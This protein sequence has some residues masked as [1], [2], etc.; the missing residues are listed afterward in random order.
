MKL[1]PAMKTPEVHAA[2]AEYKR[3]GDVRHRNRA[4]AGCMRFAMK[5]ARHYSP[6]R[7]NIDDI[8]QAACEGLLRAA[9]TYDPERAAFLTY[10]VQWIDRY[11]IIFIRAETRMVKP[12]SYERMRIVETAIREGASTI[13]EVVDYARARCANGDAQH[14][15]RHDVAAGVM[16]LLAGKDVGAEF[17]D[18]ASVH[19][20]ADDA[21][22]RVHLTIAVND[23]VEMLPHRDREVIERVFWNDEDR[24]HIGQMQ[25]VSRERIRQIMNRALERLRKQLR[26]VA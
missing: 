14:G 6:A 16:R 20:R 9:E 22:D 26:E 4:V 13:D 2:L 21:F 19:E 5:R 8:M 24:A 11:I 15:V 7:R 3:T 23:A 12:P 25:G 17:V 1:P 18:L 10:A